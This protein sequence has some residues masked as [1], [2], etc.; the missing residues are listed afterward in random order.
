MSHLPSP[1]AQGWV[2]EHLA[3]LIRVRGAST[4]LSAPLLEPS[5]RDFP[6]RWSPDAAG[7]QRLLRRILN[8]AGMKSFSP[9]IEI[10]DGP[11]AMEASTGGHA[12]QVAAWFEGLDR[13]TARFGVDVDSLNAP[14]ALVG[15]LCHEVAHAYRAC[16][17][18]TYFDPTQDEPLTDL[19]TVFL[20]FGIL[21]TNASHIYRADSV[22]YWHS[23]AGYLTPEMWSFALAVQVVAR[24]LSAKER[25]QIRRQLQTNQGAYFKEALEQLDHRTDLAQCLGLSPL[26]LVSSPN[27]FNA[28]LSVYRVKRGILRAPRCSDPDCRAKLRPSD[29]LCPGCGATIAGEVRS[30]E[31]AQAKEQAQLSTA[32]DAE[33]TRLLR[34]KS[35]GK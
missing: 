4:F 22:S 25:V 5:D 35:E 7:V 3:E 16:H 28:G 15:I 2:L 31:E 20:G 18:L 24:R 30:E 26:Q 11:E 29:T 33:L 6:D 9:E 8:Y 34:G 23:Q 13:D 17:G 32:P 14:D 27:A 21:T 1:E 10:Y 12:G 19:T